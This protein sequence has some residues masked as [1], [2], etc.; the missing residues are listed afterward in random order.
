[1]TQ[2]PWVL[3][4]NSLCACLAALVCGCAAPVRP[5]AVAT[6]SALEPPAAVQA[7]LLLRVEGPQGSQVSGLA[8][9]GEE[10]FAVGTFSGAVRLGGQPLSS[11]GGEDVFVAR[12]GL[13]GQVRWVR[14]FGGPAADKGE[15]LALGGDGSLVVVGGFSGAASFSGLTFQSEGGVDCFVVK[16]SPEEGRLRWVR[17]LG[18][19]G[20]MLCR[21]V[22]LDGA[23]DVL[24][25]GYFNGEADAGDKW[26]SAGQ[27]DAFV[28][29]LSGKDGRLKWSVPLGGAGGDMGRGV[30]VNQ[31]GA[32]FVS[33]HFS[34]EAAPEAG[35]LHLGTERLLSAGDSDAF[36]AAYTPNGQRLWVERAGGPRF[37]MAKQVVVTPQGHLVVAGLFQRDEFEGYVA[38]WSSLGEALWMKRYPAMVSSH[39][40]ALAPSGEVVVAG[41]FKGALELGRGQR[42]VSAGA[43]DVVVAAFTAQGE[44]RWAWSL[45]NKGADYGYAV[46]ASEAGVV[47]GGMLS[48]PEEPSV[49]EAFIA[50]VPPSVLGSLPP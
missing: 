50:R 23:G 39:A 29:K 49:Y 4:P 24:V 40:L 36:L 9:Q 14:R 11:V 41:H 16:L 1:M 37:D 21:Q 18:G 30:A 12:L 42:V 38:A 32:I 10:V 22:A 33:G 44:P 15:A 28:M 45:G 35:G 2:T 13:T 31:V 6:A 20:D 47:V 7:G 48:R 25:T 19:A 27:A 17:R 43:E 3:F 46:A 26:L 8:A 34:T 5:A